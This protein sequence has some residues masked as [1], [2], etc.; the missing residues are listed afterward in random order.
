MK[1]ARRF[2]LSH[3]AVAVLAVLAS[4][5]VLWFGSRAALRHQLAAAEQQQVGA[6]AL[7]AREASL[8]QQAMGISEFMRA[9]LA[10]PSVSWAALDDPSSGLRLGLPRERSAEALQALSSGQAPGTWVL[11][12]GYDGAGK[13]GRVAL[14]FDRVQREAELDQRLRVLAWPL[15]AAAFVALLLGGGLAWLLSVELIRPLT[16]LRDGTHGVRAGRLDTLVQVARADEVGDLARD[17]NAMTVELQE[18]DQMKRD[19]VNGVTHD[20]GTPLHAMRSAVNYLQ[21][22]KAG[23]LTDTQSDYLLILANAV[24][25]LKAFLENLLTVARIEA[26]KVEAYP[27]TVDPVAV[28]EELLKLY[29]P[30]AR[31]KGLELSLEPVTEAITLMADRLQFRQMALNLLTNALKFT[32]HGSISLSLRLEEGW[33]RLQVSDTGLGIEERYQQLV[34]D[35]FFRVRQPEGGPERRGTGLGLAIA[36]GLAQAH[37][38]S[39]ELYSRPAQG[40]TFTLRLP[41][42]R[43][44]A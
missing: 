41:Q 42:A 32:D 28:I 12:A 27:Q 25:L 29:E 31:E 6:F 8:N 17:F 7:A 20:L 36:R 2:F 44:S 38:G 14:G 11:Q 43:R 13:G 10:K 5:S 3:A 22:G 30:Q 40:S 15:L 21:A 16:A 4:G 37:G 26:G 24:E 23:P 39:L 9:A 34:F 33:L 18:L 1:L 19:F 35:K